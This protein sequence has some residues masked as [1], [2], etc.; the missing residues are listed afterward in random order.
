MKPPEGETPIDRCARLA[1]E[2]DELKE[3]L[4][5]EYDHTSGLQFELDDLK[6][7]CE[8][9]S[10]QLA[11]LKQIGSILATEI[12]LCPNREAHKSEEVLT[13]Y[14]PKRQ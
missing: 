7:K 5:W 11:V 9:L 14:F 2:R 12:G 6:A 4:T 13:K 10:D 8:N 1:K 3:K